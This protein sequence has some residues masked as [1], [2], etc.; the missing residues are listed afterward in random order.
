VAGGLTIVNPSPVASCRIQCDGDLRRGFIWRGDRSINQEARAAPRL[1]LPGRNST[2]SGFDQTHNVATA[3][4][5][6]SLMF[7]LIRTGHLDFQQGCSGGG[8]CADPG[9]ASYRRGVDA[10]HQHI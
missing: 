3:G 2:P 9:V 4:G 1:V 10:L 8:C 5:K 7:L 6:T